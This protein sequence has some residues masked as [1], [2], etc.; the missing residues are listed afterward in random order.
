MCFVITIELDGLVVV[1]CVTVL[2]G[3]WVLICLF[4]GLLFV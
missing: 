3:V 2:V 1:Y 4:G